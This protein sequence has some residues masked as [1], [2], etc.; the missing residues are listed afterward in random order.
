MRMVGSFSLSFSS[1][2]CL[3]LE[4]V[5]SGGSLSSNSSFAVVVLVVVLLLGDGRIGAAAGDVS[6]AGLCLA[7]YRVN[8]ILI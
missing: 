1:I 2:S 8:T 5:S 7:W 4:M 6:G 3:D